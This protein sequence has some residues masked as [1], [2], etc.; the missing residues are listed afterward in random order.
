MKQDIYKIEKGDTL[1]S[2]AEKIYGDGKMYKKLAKANNI[3]DPN[4][5]IAGK[6]L[7]LPDEDFM[8][9][10]KDDDVISN[11]SNTKSNTKSNNKSITEIKPRSSNN[12]KVLDS[13][14]PDDDN[15]YGNTTLPEVEVNAKKEF[16]P[17]NTN[18]RTL[19]KP[20]KPNNTKSNNTNQSNKK[21]YDWSKYDVESISGSIDN[22]KNE[23]TEK[24]NKSKTITRL[25]LDEQQPRFK[26][27]TV[28]TPNIR[29]E[30]DSTYKAGHPVK[31]ENKGF[32]LHH[33][34]SLN[35]NMTSVTNT[36]TNKNSGK[37]THVIIDTNGDRRVL[38]DSDKVT[39]HAGLS[40]HK[41]RNY[42]NDFMQGIE[43]IGDTNKKDLTEEQ[44]DSAIEYMMPYIKKNNLSLDDI[45][46]HEMIRNNW[47]KYAKEG[48]DKRLSTGKPDINQRNYNRI[49]DRIKQK[50]Q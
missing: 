39:F 9:N 6:S 43:F 19:Y 5:I 26:S 47:I 34:G 8:S 28:L 11:K 18:I 4:K 30:Q 21:G 10:I 50:L 32:V 7:I 3:S 17:F 16:N 29:T 1:W 40:R 49:M 25:S 14:I 48:N 24:N 20:S 45:V 13:N 38:A 35:D 27:D 33:T 37:S 12:N 22:T 2:I 31:N 23:N 42:V 15:I 36:L 46:T 44:I 41:G